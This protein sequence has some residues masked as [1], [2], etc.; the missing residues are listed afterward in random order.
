MRVCVCVWL[1]GLLDADGGGV[2][3]HEEYRCFSTETPR[4]ASRSVRWSRGVPLMRLAFS[5]NHGSA[6]AERERR[7]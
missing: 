5:A 1:Q 3:R 4:R 2:P 7:V 6:R